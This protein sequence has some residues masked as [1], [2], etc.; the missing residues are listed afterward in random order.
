[1][2]EELM[3]KEKDTSKWVPRDNDP[4]LEAQM[5][6]RFMMRLGADQA[7]VEREL[8]QHATV[9]GELA[10]IDN[11]RLILSGNHDRNMHRVG[12]AL[13]RIGLT[14]LRL[15]EANS[16]YLTQPADMETDTV[17]NKKPGIFKRWFGGKKT[18]EKEQKAQIAVAVRDTGN[19]DI[20]TLHT[21]DGKEYNAKNANEILHRLWKELR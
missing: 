10:K 15:D 20:I 12:L 5:L 4:N 3:G 18:P 7:T 21:A 1:M 13:N 17:S 19:N 16:V 8:T 2:E 9:A 14:V 11:N 6:S